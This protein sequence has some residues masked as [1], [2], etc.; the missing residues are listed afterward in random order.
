MAESFEREAAENYTGPRNAEGKSVYGHKNADV[1]IEARRRRLYKHINNGASLRANVYAHA[2]REGVSISTGWR[3]AEAIKEWYT[4][5]FEKERETV[6]ARL[7]TLR[8]RAIEGAMKSKNWQSAASLMDSLS[9]TFGD[10]EAGTTSQDVKL[11][12]SIEKQEEA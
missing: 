11:N 2:D 7:T 4:E 3:D 8:F 6:V 10:G 9:R 5:D 12:I 1:V